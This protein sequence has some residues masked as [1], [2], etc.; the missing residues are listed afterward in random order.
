VLCCSWEVVN[1]RAST[2]T[3]IQCAC[4]LRRDFARA[5]QP[6]FFVLTPFEAVGWPGHYHRAPRLG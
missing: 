3:L 1:P 6:S 4:T 2:G 5:I